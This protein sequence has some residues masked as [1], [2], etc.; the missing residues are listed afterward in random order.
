MPPVP[1]EALHKII[2]QIQ[3][4][5][6]NSSR[7]LSMVKAQL[8]GHEQ[9]K[10]RLELTRQQLDQ[11]TKQGGADVRLWQGVG[12]MFVLEDEST[13]QA[14][15]NTK[16]KELETE[17]A[18]LTK[19]QKFLE[20]QTSEAQGHMRDIFSGLEQQQKQQAA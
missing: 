8:Q 20:K 10:R 18:N 17:I 12:K 11:E 2:Q 19:K 9:G 5:L 3:T 6:V 14:K 1:D 7:Q 16:L 4:Q 15:L 13:V